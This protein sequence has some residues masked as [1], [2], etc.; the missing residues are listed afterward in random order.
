MSAD[1]V[2][3]DITL[4]RLEEMFAEPAADPFD[5]ASRYIS[6]I[7]EVVAKLRL[8]RGE[9]LGRKRLVVHLPQAAIGP[10]TQSAL[11]AALERYCTAKIAENRQVINELRVDRPRQ[12]ISALAI[13]AALILFSVLLVNFIPGLAPLS[14]AISGFVAVAV[15]VVIWEPVY[16]Y[17]YS[18]RP[19]RR[20][21]WIYEKLRAADLV[22]DAISDGPPRV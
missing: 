9:L 11:Q 18:W 13:S 19:Y 4:N 5:P 20:D 1:Y 3:M 15:W 16:N 17:I 10:E 6:G 2:E 21:V 14:G 22:V 7:D 12:L 8:L